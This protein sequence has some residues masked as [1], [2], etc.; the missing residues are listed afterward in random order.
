[1]KLS[2]VIR[3]DSS[4]ASE[5]FFTEQG[6]LMDTPVVTSTGIF[7][8]LNPDGSI[9]R[10]LRLPEEV[11]NK[12][13]LASFTGKPVIISHDAGTITKDNVMQEIVGTILEP[14]FQDGDDVKCKIVVHDIDKVKALRARELS[15]GYTLDLDETPGEWNGQHYDAIQ[16]N[17]RVNHL[18]IVEKARAGDQA[19]LN[20]DG[21]S[22]GYKS[23]KGGNEMAR[24][25]FA[26]MS[27]A[28]LMKAFQAFAVRMKGDRAD[29]DDT[30]EE[31]ETNEDGDVERLMA[32]NARLK[33]EIAKL[34]GENGD[35]DDTETEEDED[36]LEENI[37]SGEDTE[38]VTEDEDEETEED[39]EE[40]SEDGADC[41]LNKDAMEKMLSEKLSVCRVGDKLHMDGLEDM[42][43]TQA[44]RAIIKKV[45]PSVRLDSD[46]DVNGAYK[47]ALASINRPK[48]VNYQRRQMGNTRSR[49]DSKPTGAAAARA[50]M[51]A[52]EGG[53]D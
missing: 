20:L 36:D 10:E 44:K 40:L 7:E 50:A 42:T 9:R 24:K 26:E 8:Y 14:G 6:F 52:R 11:F 39:E 34:R 5:T 43:I 32:E 21:Q 25:E 12:E 16:R 48:D 13:Y 18:A 17:M 41:K 53:N 29:E 3:I 15:L 23:T 4:P 51:I 46:A 49:M 28:E 37:D 31:P 22:M 35:E 33:A 38:E 30:A 27:T 45:N 2:R 1:M 19:H 47:F